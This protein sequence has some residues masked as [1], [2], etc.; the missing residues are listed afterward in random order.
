M[1]VLIFLCIVSI[2]L[3]HHDADAAG[4]RPVGQPGTAVPTRT[5]PAVDAVILQAISDGTIPGA[6]LIV[7]HDGRVIYRKAY[8]AR[9]LEPRRGPMTLDTVFYLASL[10]KAI[11]TTTAGMALRR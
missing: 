9:A 10:T 5:F 7:G 6:V 3:F 8:G 4:L 2:C 1:S 11:V